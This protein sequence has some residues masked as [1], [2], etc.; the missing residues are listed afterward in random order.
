MRQFAKMACVGTA[1]LLAIGAAAQAAVV[2][3]YV[4]PNEITGY[5]TNDLSAGT[6]QWVV[7]GSP[8]QANSNSPAAL[9]AQTTSN[10]PSSFG[11]ISVLA[12]A[13]FAS[14]NNGVFK[15]AHGAGYGSDPAAT[16]STD[17]VA[18]L[19]QSNAIASLQFTH[20]LLAG[21]ETMNVYVNQ[22]SGVQGPDLSLSATMGSGGTPYA[23]T[24]VQ[25]TGSNFGPNGPWGVVHL[26]IS[27]GSAGDILTFTATTNVTGEAGAANWWG[28]GIGAATVSV[29]EPASLSLLSIGGLAL[30]ARHRRVRA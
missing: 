1:G 27:G 9:A 22:V 16:A 12:G 3:G 25:L 24:N 23:A 7:Y 17:S 15:Y 13:P 11:G 29:P 8:G 28:V 19:A 14:G 30:L 5:Q 18:I 2:T 10:S 6:T 21:N 20:T 26:T 4:T